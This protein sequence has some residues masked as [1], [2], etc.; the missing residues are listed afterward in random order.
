MN[1]DA[2]VMNLAEAHGY[3]I[4]PNQLAIYVKDL[5][6]LDLTDGEFDILARQARREFDRFPS[7]GQLLGI[8]RSFTR[9]RSKV[10]PQWILFERDGH[11][12][13][14]KMDD[15]AALAKHEEDERKW[16]E[17]AIKCPPEF[18][19]LWF[20][21]ADKMAMEDDDVDIPF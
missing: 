8:G 7:I 17:N 18:K 1:L 13:A 11:T 5:A 6:E 10:E 21:V 15:R 19:H 3:H 14:K 16:R 4:K 12:Y 9:T 20:G 2:W